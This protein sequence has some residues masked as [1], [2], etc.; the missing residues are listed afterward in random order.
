M[1]DTV[2]VCFYRD[3]ILTRNSASFS[4]EHLLFFLLRDNG[5]GVAE[6]EWRKPLLKGADL[7]LLWG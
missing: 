4:M 3:N 7:P 1:G 2:A 5:F 6:L